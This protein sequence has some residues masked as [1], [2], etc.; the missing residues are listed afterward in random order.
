MSRETSRGKATLRQLCNSFK[1]S[2]QAYY[3]SRGSCGKEGQR[4]ALRQG[5]W[6]SASELEVSIERVVKGRP[7]WG[8]RKVWVYLRR[9]G[10]IASRKRVWAI[11]R[12]KGLVLPWVRERQ[13]VPR[14]GQVV[15]A[16]SN[17]AWAGLGHGSHHGLDAPRIGC[18]RGGCGLRGSLRVG[19]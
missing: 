5:T 18:H 1:V 4:R 17:P 15:V 7:G 19:L 14:G 6:A 9:E 16:E 2:A 10:L 11:M 3:R 13:D 12:A 8:V